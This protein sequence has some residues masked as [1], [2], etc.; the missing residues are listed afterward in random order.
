M[1][2]DRELW[3]KV[4]GD[5]YAPRIFVTEAGHIGIAVGGIVVIGE[6]EWWHKIGCQARGPFMLPK[7]S[8]TRV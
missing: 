2:T 4:Q 5:F 1:N 3:R 7:P 8:D 6:V